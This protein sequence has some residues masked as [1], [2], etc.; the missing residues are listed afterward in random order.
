MGIKYEEKKLQNENVK[1]IPELK[2]VLKM[3]T[4]NLWS[5]VIITIRLSKDNNIEFQFPIPILHR[6][7][8]CVQFSIKLN[9]FTKLSIL[10]WALGQT[11]TTLRG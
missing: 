3:E 1:K 5:F 6:D 2:I 9:Q 4:D 11:Y 7:V 10:H 8:G